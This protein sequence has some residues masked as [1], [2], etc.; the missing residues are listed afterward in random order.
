MSSAA[1]ASSALAL[2]AAATTTPVDVAHAQSAFCTGPGQI[3]SPTLGTVCGP[4]ATAGG[5]RSTAVGEFNTASGEATTAVGVEN[6]AVATGGIGNTAVGL[7]L[8]HI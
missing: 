2:I 5:S 8:I 4:F 6:I 1:F 7:S 3:V